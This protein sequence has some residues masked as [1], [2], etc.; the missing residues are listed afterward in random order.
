MFDCYEFEFDFNGNITPAQFVELMYEKRTEEGVV[1]M[2]GGYDDSTFRGDSFSYRCRMDWME[3]DAEKVIKEFDSLYNTIKNIAKQA[4]TLD[5]TTE[6]AKQVLNAKQFKVW[7]TYLCDFNADGFDL[8]EVA[9]IKDR[10]ETVK[11]V[12]DLTKRH[13]EGKKLEDGEKEFLKE[14]IDVSVSPEEMKKY[15]EYIA[16][17]YS[18]CEKRVG[19]KI[20]AYKLIIRAKRVY[21]LL[22]LNAPEHVINFE[23]CMLAAMLAVHE[24]GVSM[25][26]VDDN[27]RYFFERFDTDD[28]EILDELFRIKKTNK[29]K[30]LAPLFIYFIIHD[31]S[32]SE[33]H[34]K[35]NDIA[36]YL[37]NEHEITIERKAVSR[38]V[39]ALADS[40]L[41]I[42]ADS[43]LGVWMEK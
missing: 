19:K 23:A 15:N 21:K 16:C 27:T 39:H 1:F 43:K 25:E 12:K 5:G 22:T 6:N 42:Y 29:R 37:E 36:A 13:S 32:D 8:D 40:Q 38:T 31:H 9:D 18:E 4:N 35:F 41:G 24:Y 26:P 3:K 34:L 33:H 10:I 11:I 17:I 7:E 20:C 28:D 14:Y 30:T 2:P